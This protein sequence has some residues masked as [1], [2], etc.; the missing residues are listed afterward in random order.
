MCIKISHFSEVADTKYLIVKVSKIQLYLHTEMTAVFFKGP[1]I[2]K[3]IL[4]C[5]VLPGG[6]VVM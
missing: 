5:D 3:S 6:N 1:G 4:F 2:S